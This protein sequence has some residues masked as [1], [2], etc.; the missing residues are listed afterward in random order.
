LE[1]V[2]KARHVRP[3]LLAKIYCGLG[4]NDL[5]FEWLERAFGEHDLS[6]TFLSTDECFE[7]LRFDTRY[8]RF[9]AR[10]RIVDTP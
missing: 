2:A 6:L 8:S 3:Y 7:T 5:A 4:Q 9:L 10:L 1:A